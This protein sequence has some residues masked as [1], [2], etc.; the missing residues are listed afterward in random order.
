MLKQSRRNFLSTLTR[1]G[2]YAAGGSLLRPALSALADDDPVLA[3]RPLVRY[4]EKTDLILL[5]S[6]PP[7]L[8]TP[9][10]YFT[11][12]ITPNEAFFVRYHVTPIP[13][14]V[15]L[16]TWRLKVGGVVERP[17]ELSIDDLKNQFDSVT[18]TA[19]AQCSG[20]SRGRFSPRVFGGQWGDG[21]M[22]CATW[23]GVRLRDVLTAVGIKKEAVDVT[24]NG[25]DT[26]A[27]PSVPDMMKSLPAAR[28][29]E[30]S[31][32]LIAYQM[33]GEPLPMLNGFPARLIVPG[34]FAD[35]WIKNLSEIRVLDRADENFWTKSAYRIP[36]TPCGCVEPGATPQRT[37]PISRLKVRS[38]IASPAK[39]ARI[40]VDRPVTLQGIAFDGGLGIAE[41]QISH[42]AGLTWH[43]ARLGTDLGRFAFREWSFAWTPHKAGRYRVQVRAFNTIGESQSETPLWN[44]SGYQRNVVEQIE[45]SVI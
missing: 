41:V 14:R 1:A 26:P 13:T 40:P 17:L 5:T 37:V 34:W 30:D 23:T 3:G 29:L 11:R 27:F 18:V 45:L 39:G 22:G 6:R 12:A 7:Q 9:M 21:A 36:D 16:A 2:V 4:P 35:Y 20:N 28:I 25:L 32:I 44:P 38:F 33:N 42:D 19:V 31:D 15:D 24:F 43:R 8:E 10:K